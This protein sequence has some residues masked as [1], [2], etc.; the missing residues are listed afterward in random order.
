MR[1]VLTFFGTDG[2]GKSTIARELSSR[3][4]PLDIPVMGGSSYKEWLTE[5]VAVATL[6]KNH[7]LNELSSSFEDKT[8]LYEDIAIACYGVAAMKRANGEGVIIDSDPYLKRLIWGTLGMNQ[9]DALKYINQFDNRFTDRLGPLVRPDKIIAINMGETHLSSEDLLQRLSDRPDNSEHDPT[10]IESTTKL[11]NRVTEV[12][13]HIEQSAVGMGIIAVLNTRL[14]NIDILYVDNP[15]AAPDDL[16][17][18][19]Q[20]I[21][22]EITQKIP[23]AE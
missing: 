4:A 21:V 12:W 11:A 8:R 22:D 20:R 10:D 5:D 16:G 15:A 14:N 6:G 19:T 7:R 3:Y 9:N 18:Q 23:S 13:K 2:S 17:V 1:E